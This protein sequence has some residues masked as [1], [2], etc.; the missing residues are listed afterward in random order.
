MS[1]YSSTVVSTILRVEPRAGCRECSCAAGDVGAGPGEGVAG[2]DK[3]LYKGFRAWRRRRSGRGIS[4]VL[5]L[6][7]LFLFSNSRYYV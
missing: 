2:R 3:V 7:F 5:V 6:S 1:K 4:I